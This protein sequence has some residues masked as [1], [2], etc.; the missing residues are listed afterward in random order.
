MRRPP[1][2]GISRGAFFAAAAEA[3]SGGRSIL[4]GPPRSDS[5]PQSLLDH[6]QNVVISLVQLRV[7]VTILGL[8]ILV[9]GNVL[10]VG[11]FEKTGD[12]GLALIIRHF[13]F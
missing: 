13:V 1:T 3:L 7:C 12:F 11:S 10:I 5:Q 2:L 9:L 8:R 4:E 6:D